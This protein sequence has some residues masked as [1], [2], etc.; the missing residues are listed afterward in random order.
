MK[1][2]VGSTLNLWPYTL[3]II[4]V[5][6]WIYIAT[7]ASIQ[8]QEYSVLPISFFEMNQNTLHQ[9]SGVQVPVIPHVTYI[10]STPII[11]SGTSGDFGFYIDEYDS[12]GTWV[13]GQWKGIINNPVDQIVEF[14]YAPTSR[15][16]SFAAPQYYMSKDSK[17]EAYIGETE[18]KLK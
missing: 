11:I 6:L 14:D 4:G 8:A 3:I 2:N 5:C 18:L 7:F 13:S 17:L 1:K 10:W 15:V 9:V 12:N 16:V